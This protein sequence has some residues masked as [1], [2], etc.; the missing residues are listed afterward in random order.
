V[1]FVLHNFASLSCALREPNPQSPG[2][3]RAAC[4]SGDDEPASRCRYTAVF[5][6]ALVGLPGMAQSWLWHAGTLPGEDIP[7]LEMVVWLW[8][9]CKL[10]EEVLQ[11]ALGDWRFWKPGKDRRSIFWWNNPYYR[12]MWNILDLLTI[13]SVLGTAAMRVLVLF[14]CDVST[15][16]QCM[17]REWRGALT[18]NYDTRRLLLAVSQS[19]YAVAIILSCLPGSLRTRALPLLLPLQPPPPPPPPPP[20]LLLLPPPPPLLL[21]LL[22]LLLALSTFPIW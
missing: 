11:G 20:P 5:T 1:R 14:D 10:L 17:F 8:T 4:C 2:A 12:S 19:M 3:A 6:V 13:Y 9:A 22:L 7:I 15:D 21:L 18:M 16:T